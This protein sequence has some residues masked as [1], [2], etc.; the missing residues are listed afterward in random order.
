MDYDGPAAGVYSAGSFFGPFTAKT[1]LTVRVQP[2]LKF[3]GGRD[4]GF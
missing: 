4:F 2:N 3:V 1:K